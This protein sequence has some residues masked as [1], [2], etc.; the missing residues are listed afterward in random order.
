[1]TQTHVL[2]SRTA[3]KAL[4]QADEGLNVFSHRAG[5]EL[6]HAGLAYPKLVATSSRDG[7]PLPYWILTPEGLNRRQELAI[8]RGKS[9]KRLKR[10]QFPAGNSSPCYTNN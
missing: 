1:M 5:A 7:K 9:A 2:L 8:S 4:K 10:Q 3:Q 6:E